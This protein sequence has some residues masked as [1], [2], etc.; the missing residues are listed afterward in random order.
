M[1]LKHTSYPLNRVITKDAK[2]THT[3]TR[4]RAHTHSVTKCL[5]IVPGSMGGKKYIFADDMLEI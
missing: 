4:A 2:G 1:S 3:H 5:A